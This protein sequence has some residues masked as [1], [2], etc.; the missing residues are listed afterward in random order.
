L[1]PGAPSPREGGVL[2]TML[3]RIGLHLPLL[4][5]A[6]PLSLVAVG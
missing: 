4:Q 3:L 6:V 2:A 5:Q 1:V